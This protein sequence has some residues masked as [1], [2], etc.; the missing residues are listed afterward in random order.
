MVLYVFYHIGPVVVSLDQ[1][2]SLPDSEITKVVM[3]LLEDGFYQGFRDDCVFIFLAIFP[4]Y[5]V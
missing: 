4:I 3:H 1:G 2:K 5:V